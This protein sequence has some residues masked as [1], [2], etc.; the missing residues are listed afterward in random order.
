MTNTDKG[1]ALE[2]KVGRMLKRAKK[3]T[4]GNISYKHKPEIILS[5]GQPRVPDFQVDIS[6][7]HKKQRIFVECE[8][9]KR[10]KNDLLEKIHFIRNNHRQKTF[11]FIYP[12]RISV[13]LA[14]RFTKQ[15]ITHR[16]LTQF[17]E[18]LS[19][20]VST[21]NAAWSSHN[22]SQ[23]IVVKPNPIRM[24]QLQQSITEFDAYP[25]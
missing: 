8:D 24:A 7:P 9:R 12:K 21:V 15:G 22:S 13:T 6:Y 10:N 25:E 14:E 16:S 17:R 2:A 23:Q 20:E 4:S 19:G 3:Q 5:D 18:F 11:I 1:D